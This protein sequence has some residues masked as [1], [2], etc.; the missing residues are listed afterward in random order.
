[1]AL[2]L[3][4]DKHQGGKPVSRGTLLVTNDTNFDESLG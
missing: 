4:E 2:D 1:M 3:M